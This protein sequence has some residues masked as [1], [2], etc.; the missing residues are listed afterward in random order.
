MNQF[1]G[2]ADAA[3][4]LGTT[5]Y[6]VMELCRTGQL[7]SGCIEG[8]TVIPMAAVQGYAQRASIELDLA[9]PRLGGASAPRGR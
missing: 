1:V 9:Q 4:L 8:V 5:S 2:V 3:Q 7:P 6:H